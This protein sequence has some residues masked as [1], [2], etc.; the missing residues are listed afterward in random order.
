MANNFR[1]CFLLPSESRVLVSFWGEP[2]RDS[3]FALLR[4][5][6]ARVSS[7]RNVSLIKSVAVKRKGH[8]NLKKHDVRKGVRTNARTPFVVGRGV[9]S[10]RFICFYRLFSAA[11][12]HRPTRSQQVKPASL[13]MGDFYYSFSSSV[14]GWA[15]AYFAASSRLSSRRVT[16]QTE[17]TRKAVPETCI[18]TVGICSPSGLSAPQTVH[19]HPALTVPLLF[20]TGFH[21]WSAFSAPQLIH[22]ATH[23]ALGTSLCLTIC[24]PQL[25]HMYSQFPLGEKECST[26]FDILQITHFSTHIP[27]WGAHSCP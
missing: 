8:I 18:L 21:L 7:Q 10:R 3:T 17:Q 23:P 12:R 20:F 1:K 25:V 14:W 15:A 19:L 4:M 5:T 6:W 26:S 9:I 16:P 22:T 2:A 11:P 27:G 24:L 13:P